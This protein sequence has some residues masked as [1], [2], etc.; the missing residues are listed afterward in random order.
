[1]PQGEDEYGVKAH[2][3]SREELYHRAKASTQLRHVSEGRLT[4]WRE[5]SEGGGA[6]STAEAQ[7]E[8][9]G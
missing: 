2:T 3:P 5:G 1:M 9:E 7:M 6:P 8:R 4:Q